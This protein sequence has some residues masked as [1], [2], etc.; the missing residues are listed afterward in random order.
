MEESFK[1]G[2]ENIQSI[3]SG[4]IREFAIDVHLN[5]SMS[6]ALCTVLM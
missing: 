5:L 6:Y 2:L 3:R 1:D 4:N